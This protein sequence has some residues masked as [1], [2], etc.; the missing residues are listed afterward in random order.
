MTIDS[1]AAGGDG[2]GRDQGGRVVFVPHSA[3]GDTVTVRLTEARKDFARA[4]VVEVLAPASARVEPLCGH[5]RAGECGGC[6]WLHVERGAQEEAKTDIVAR[7]LRRAVAAGMVLR[8]LR[9]EVSSYHWRRRA[10]LHW[11][12]PR[13]S[14]RA[15]LGFLAPRSHR[16]SDITGCVQ[17]VP[18]LAQAL[19]V[20]RAELAPALGRSGQ[21]ELLAGHQGDVQV[22][23]RGP[24]GADEAA[25]LVGQGPI[26][27]VSLDPRGDGPGP[28]R[29]RGRS[30][31]TSW[32]QPHIELEP[33]FLG[34][35]DWFAQ[36]S[37][38]GNLALLALV[39]EATAPRANARVLELYAGSGNFTRRLAADTADYVAVDRRRPPWKPSGLA[40]VRF[41][42][43]D[44]PEVVAGLAD[45]GARFDVV[46]LD[47][48][49][50]GARAALA[51]LA[52]LKPARIVY[53]SC[54][55]ATLGRDIDALAELGYR[56][57]WA[58]PFDL[59]PQTAHVEVMVKLERVDGSAPAPG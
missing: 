29:P 23:I 14:A 24:A 8:P 55:P 7:G 44:V 2:V 5:F 51:P 21:I 52:A 58:Q 10:R 38:A 30:Q 43:G 3:P 46:V 36:A 1:L 57:Q 37:R 50:A 25:A 48:P 47:P 56:A 15:L 54:D 39:D 4:E 53:V 13:K 49:R 32:G 59:M 31:R 41:M 9:T 19:D 12:R 33:G 18:A 35:A 27:G 22:A 45:S 17:L 6:Q 28:G 16:V 11:Y 20:L 34:R 26:V 42:A 40:N